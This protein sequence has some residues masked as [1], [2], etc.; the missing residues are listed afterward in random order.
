M[1]SAALSGQP[2]SYGGTASFVEDVS[3]HVVGDI[4]HADLHARPADADGSDEELHLVF[5]P[6][7]DMLDGGPDL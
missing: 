2:A 7:E 3:E 6:G 5:L 1:K 4:C